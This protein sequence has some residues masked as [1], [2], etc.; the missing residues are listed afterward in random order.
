MFLDVVLVEFVDVGVV[1]FGLI[2]CNVCWFWFWY[3]GGMDMIMFVVVGFVWYF[4][5][6]LLCCYDWF[7]LCYILYLV[8]LYFYNGFDVVVLEGVIIV[9]NVMVCVL[10]LYVYVLYCI[11][12]CFY[13]GCNWVI[14]C[15][16][17]RGEVYVVC[18]LCEVDCIVLLFDFVCEVIQLYLGGGMFNFFDVV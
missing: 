10:L 1:M 3:V 16:C 14:I 13:C 18:V 11:S 2:W 5:F 7:G 9:S 6:E 17:S 4:D 12:L 15:D 8:V